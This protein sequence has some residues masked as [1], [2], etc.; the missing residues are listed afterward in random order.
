MS[1]NAI[2]AIAAG[3]GLLFFA[4]KSSANASQPSLFRTVSNMLPEFPETS[5]M[6]RSFIKAKEGFSNTA[7][8]DG[9]GYSIGYGHQIVG[10]DGLSKDSV[11]TRSQ[12]EQLLNHDIANAQRIVRRYVNVPLN[13]YQNAALVSFVYNLGEGN[14]R[15]S[16]LLRKLNDGDYQ[17]AADEF[18]RW[19]Y[20][21]GQVLP[22]LVSRR[23]SERQMFIS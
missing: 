14:F 3:L 18:G 19:V 1:K 10:G 4:Q 21:G 15:D 11:I 13:E 5:E 6:L 9:K 23:E 22:G 16:T 2:L 7:Y 20:A 8:P 17:G 12:A